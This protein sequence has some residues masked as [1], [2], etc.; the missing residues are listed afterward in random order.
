[1]DYAAVM[2]LSPISGNW[3]LMSSGGKVIVFD[4]ERVAWEWMP[5]LGQGRICRED[6]A[7]KQISFLELSRELPNCARVISPYVPG[8]R[9]PWKAHQIWSE[10]WSGV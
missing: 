1:M 8:E 5:M 4:T 2:V 3:E 9:Q 10:W 6:E 7:K